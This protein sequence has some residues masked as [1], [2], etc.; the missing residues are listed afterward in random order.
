VWSV[1]RGQLPGK[2]ENLL[3]LPS[4]LF[5]CLVRGSIYIDRCWWDNGEK[6]LEKEIGAFGVEVHRQRSVELC[7]WDAEGYDGDCDGR[8]GDLGSWVCDG[9]EG[10]E[11]GT[12][13]GKDD[14][15]GGVEGD[16]VATVGG[17]VVG[18]RGVD[19]E[20]VGRH[21][22]REIVDHD[23]ELLRESRG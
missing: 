19:G 14:V 20:H 9:T 4:S 2:G 3:S 16:F 7:G 17:S 15:V 11:V 12:V 8:P 1:S 5:R 22:G 13:G 23:G 18:L 10:W 6:G 21:L